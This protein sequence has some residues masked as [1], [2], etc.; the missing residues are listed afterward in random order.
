MAE[1][2]LVTD[3]PAIPIGRLRERIG[4]EI[5]VSDWILVDQARI[6]GFA[7]VTDDQQWIHIDPAAA[8][9]SPFGGTIAHGF[10]TLSLLAPMSYSA[11]PQVE[12]LRTGVNYGF[13]SVRFLTP[14]RSGKR[15]R[16]RFVLRDLIERSPGRWQMTV[17]ASVEIEGETKPALIAEWMFLYFIG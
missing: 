8:A 12:G 15:V 1:P 10:L 6:D 16:G 5:G 4:E 9:Q 17:N 7:D 11:L 14:V 13:N 2:G 3:T